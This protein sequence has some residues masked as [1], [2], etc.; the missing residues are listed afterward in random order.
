MKSLQKIM[1]ENEKKQ[2]IPQR[3]EILEQKIE[4]LESSVDIIESR[5]SRNPFTR[6]NF[7]GQ[8]SMEL[9]WN[10]PLVDKRLEDE[11]YDS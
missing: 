6:D 2:Y 8:T 10:G 3:L 4:D 5:L 7:R 9:V 1:N 11:D